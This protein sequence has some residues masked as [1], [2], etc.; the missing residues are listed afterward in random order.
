MSIQRK[1][2]QATGVLYTVHVYNTPRFPSGSP[3]PSRI[4]LYASE[5]VKDNEF[6]QHKRRWSLWCMRHH[7]YIL[8]GIVHTITGK[9]SYGTSG[10][11]ITVDTRFFD[12]STRQKLISWATNEIIQL[13]SCVRLLSLSLSLLSTFQK[14][15]MKNRDFFGW[16]HTNI[17][18]RDCCCWS[19]RGYGCV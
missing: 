5:T 15:G 13:V 12:K 7:L 10:T 4:S 2:L 11:Y 9:T 19:V 17:V 6:F 3:W 14:K 16:A 1:I 18:P 8:R